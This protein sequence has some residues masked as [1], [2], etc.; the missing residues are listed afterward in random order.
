MGQQ[1]AIH[2]FVLGT[3]DF[4]DKQ[5]EFMY[6]KGWYSITDIVGEE[7]NIIYKSRNAQEAY[8]K[9]NIYIGR[10]K[11][12]L[13]PEERKRQREERYEKKERTK[14]R[15]P[16]DIG[17]HYGH[18][19]HRQQIFQSIKQTGRYGYLSFCWIISC[20]PVFTIGAAS[21]AL[22]DTSRRVIHRDEGYVW[23]GYWHAFKVNFKQATKAWLVQLIILIVL[24][25]DIYI[26]WSGLKTGN[27]WGAFS[28]VFIIMALIAAAWAI[29]TSAYISRFEQVTKITLKNTILILIANLPWTLLVIVI[30]VVSLILA[31]IIIPL[32]FI[33]PVGAALTYEFIFERIFR[34]LMPEEDRLRE[35]EKDKEYRD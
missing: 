24:L 30:L 29:Y 31:W 28:I 11:E 16:Q 13:T 32:I 20:I 27:Q 23:R 1:H 9:W 12:R 3:K 6:D 10:K 17:G 7:K 5:S 26:T 34:K 18:F 8:L 19:Q 21:T 22:Y 2:K 25:G 33:L 35:E 4:D 14:Q 15:A